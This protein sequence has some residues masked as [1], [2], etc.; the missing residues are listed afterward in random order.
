MLVILLVGGT[1]GTPLLVQLEKSKPLEGQGWTGIIARICPEQLLTK[2]FKNL[3]LRHF[4]RNLNAIE[5]KLN[6]N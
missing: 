3:M 2:H 1:L 4:L 5:R 6:V